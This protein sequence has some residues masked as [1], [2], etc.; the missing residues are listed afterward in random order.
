MRVYTVPN[1]RT[2]WP[3]F[4]MVAWGTVAFLFILWMVSYWS[5]LR[6]SLG[7]VLGWAAALSVLSVIGF[8]FFVSSR[9][10]L[11]T[12]VE[13]FQFEV[14][15]GTITQRRVGHLTVEIPLNQ[16]ES[17]HDF[18]NWLVIKGG[19]P[20]REITIPS[21]V[22]GFQELKQQLSAYRAIA[23]PK[24]APGIYVS[25]LQLFL[26]IVGCCLLFASHSR[27]IILAAGTPL[28]LVEGLML[29][30]TWLR[31]KRV[32]RPKLLLAL[33]TS[34]WVLTAWIVCER[35]RAAM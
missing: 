6:D 12:F 15:D 34:T 27:S 26:V 35:F 32:L 28:L 23:P 29:Y 21:A 30:S 33:Y 17:I 31:R 10:G 3:N 24:T 20:P 19:E 7:R 1:D 25:V 18:R 22:G 16:I 5:G 2:T 14:S 9:Y 8:A 13:K 11:W 4:K